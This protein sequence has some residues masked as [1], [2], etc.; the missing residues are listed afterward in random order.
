MESRKQDAPPAR[1]DAAEQA[2]ALLANAVDGLPQGAL[3]ER[4]QA[5]IERRRPLRVKLGI[6]PTAPDIHLGH[7]VVLRK[8]REFQDLGHKVVLIIGDTTAQVGD[9]SGRSTLRP[10]LSSQEIEANA[11]TFQRQATMIL[12]D[13]PERLEI[14][15][16]GEWLQMALPELLALMRTTTVAQIVE[17]EDFAQRLAARKPVSVLEMIY[18]LL[19]GYDSV[20]VQADVELGGTDQKF[21]LLLGRD[22]QRAYQQPQQAV[23]TMPILVGTDGKRKMSKSL[24]NQI[25]ITDEPAE[26]Y[27]K[28]MAIPDEAMPKYFELLLHREQPA[29]LAPRDAKRLLAREIVGWLHGAHQAIAAQDAF[30]RLFLERKQPQE[31]AEHAFASNGEAVHLPALIG[32]AFGISRSQARRLIDEGAVSLDQTPLAAGQYDEAPERLD[33]RVLQVGKR[34]FCRLRAA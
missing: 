2:A 1:Q 3:Q 26:M 16:N 23:V 6:D 9:P 15:R 14:R 30:D 34:R 32:D 20:A 11:A 27:G 18:P 24:G 5:A 4:L 8:L 12:D 19:Q 13:S 7:A 21:N 22:I 28:T 29:E 17:R 10:L 33:G 25:G 31:V